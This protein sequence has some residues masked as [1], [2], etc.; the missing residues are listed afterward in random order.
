M[1]KIMDANHAVAVLFFSI[2]EIL[3]GEAAMG[4]TPLNKE[5]IYKHLD[6]G[7][8]FTVQPMSTM[9]PNYCAESLF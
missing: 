3:S 8:N 2:Q 5:E 1:L 9:L 6:K 4:N 7:K